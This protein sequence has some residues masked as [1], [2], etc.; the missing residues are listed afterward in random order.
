VLL[1]PEGT[2]L[3][4]GKT[5]DISSPLSLER[6]LDEFS[7]LLSVSILS[8]RHRQIWTHLNHGLYDTQE[9]LVRREQSMSSSQGVT[10]QPTLKSVLREHL[11]NPSTIVGSLGIPL[12]VPVG[13]LETFIKL[14]G[15][16][17]VGREDSE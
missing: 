5:G 8:L 13:D 11:N 14:V 9:R 16:E 7:V 3:D 6:H 1:S 2:G 15:V 4:V 10:L 12:E 17:L